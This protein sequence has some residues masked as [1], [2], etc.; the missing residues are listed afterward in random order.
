MSSSVWPESLRNFC[1]VGVL[2]ERLL[3]LLVE[4]LLDL[5]VGDLD[6]LLLGLALDPLEGDQQLEH[7][8]AQGVVLLLALGLEL[9][10]GDLRLAL[11]GL[12]RGLALLR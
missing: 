5:G 11:G 7:L 2:G 4:G 12:R 6:V 8:V 3:L 1:E 10:V 9:A